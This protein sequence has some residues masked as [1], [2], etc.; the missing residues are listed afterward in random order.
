[1][2]AED[3]KALRSVLETLQF[4]IGVCINSAESLDGIHDLK[5]VTE[6]L[7]QASKLLT[8]DLEKLHD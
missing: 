1:M 5:V 4:N 2:S 3:T 8:E 6:Y 7:N